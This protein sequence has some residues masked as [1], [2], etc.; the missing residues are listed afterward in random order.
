MNQIRLISIL[1]LVFMVGCSHV[2]GTGRSQ[3]NMVSP[4]QEAEL[5]A[6]A[7]NEATA[8]VTLITSG[9]E[10]EMVR[11]VGRR[12]VNA[13]EVLYPES[14]VEDDQWKFVLIDDDSVQNAWAAPGGKV[15]IYTGILPVTKTEAGLAVVMAHE[16]A[17]VLAHHS[18]EQI[19]HALLMNG[20]LSAGSA[21]MGDSANRAI[22]MQALGVGG[23]YG[24]ALPFS[25]L[26][27][28]EADELGLFLMAEAGYD[29]RTAIAVWERM[30][31]SGSA[32]PPEFMSTHPAPENRI[33][34]F[35]RLM[36]EAMDLYRE[37]EQHRQRAKQSR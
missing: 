28:A 31:E 4:A 6:E 33:E 27:E 23:Q 11:R 25:R 35:E 29:P 18:A 5:G 14:M 8:E 30:G 13:A 19:S 17:H 37:A 24:V 34:E 36:P 12:I 7:F 15:A 10:A 16:V 2:A 3:L 1:L 32:R 22:V 20:V 9:P 26:H 21:A